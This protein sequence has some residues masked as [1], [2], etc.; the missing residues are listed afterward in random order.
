MLVISSLAHVLYRRRPTGRSLFLEEEID[1]EVSVIG[2]G[3]MRIVADIEGHAC[4]GVC[5][6]IVDGHNGWVMLL[7]NSEWELD[8]DVV[9]IVACPVLG[10]DLYLSE[11][12][13]AGQSSSVLTKN[14]AG[15]AGAWLS[16]D[17]TIFHVDN[18][19]ITADH[20]ILNEDPALIQ[21]AVEIT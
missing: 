11:G 5:S 14:G 20:A 19:D 6:W 16:V 12:S 13:F 17:S 4:N 10:I 7:D 8:I 3:I 18:A 1:L 9:L 21:P 2:L 15:I